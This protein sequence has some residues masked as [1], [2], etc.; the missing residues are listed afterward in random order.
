MRFIDPDGMAPLDHIFNSK[1]EFIR[2][3]KVGN[4]VKIQIGNKLY[5]P[6]QLSTSM[7]SRKAIAKIGAFYAGKIGAD[8]GTKI[9]T[10]KGDIDSNKNP[11]FT[12]DQ[13]INLNTNGGFSESL[14]DISN[15]KNIMKHENAHKEDNENSKF[16]S[17]LSTHADVYN[18]QMSDS[19]FGSTTDE[20]KIGTAASFGNYL[21]N[22]DQ[23]SEFGVNEILSKVETFNASNKGGL[24]IQTPLGAF[25]KG[26]LYL[27]LI[28]KK[29][30]YP[31]DYE[32][33][34]R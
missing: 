30:T 33:V 17:T 2:D 23:S 8:V 6:S 19:S 11:A 34:D 29:Q 13:T 3:T 16:E 1:G 32:K 25:S 18:I 27:D 20:F 7:G 15:F 24:Q 12:K 22:M 28:Y 21:L 14:N 5:N 9:S 31:I 26:T 4:A 10:A